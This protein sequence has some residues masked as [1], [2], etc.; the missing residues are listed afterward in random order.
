[1]LLKRA[2]IITHDNETT[3]VDILLE[4][5]KIK[6]IA[7]HIDIPQDE[8]IDLDGKLVISGAI[9]VHVHLREP[10]YEDKETIATGSAAAAHGGF[11]TILAMPNVNPHP[12][13]V[14]TLKHY[15]KDIDTKAVVNVIPYAN[16]TMNAMGKQLVD[17]DAIVKAGW[18]Y[19]SDDGVGVQDEAMMEKAMRAAYRNNAIIVAHTEDNTYLK[20]GACVNEGIASKRLGLVGIPNACEYAQVK[21]DLALALK[22]KAA[23][24]ICHMSTK[25]SVAA[26]REARAAGANVSGEVTTHHLLLNE[27]DV[28][29]TLEKMNPPLRSRA[30]QQA[31]I[32]GIKENH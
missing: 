12:D 9:D 11:T 4:N 10:G 28:T 1:M 20:A 26:L 32:E 3:I 31:L 16:I 29:G 23:Y 7:P 8:V 27:E 30:D 25:E 17:F 21:R 6:Q 15:Q 24:H 14:E 22:T 19:F 13:N 18:R 2:S 5:N